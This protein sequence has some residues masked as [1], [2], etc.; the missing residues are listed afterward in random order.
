[1]AKLTVAE[2][3]PFIARAAGLCESDARVVRF[4]NRA[5]RRLLPKG[6]WVNTVQRYRICTNSDCITWPR[7]IETIEAFAV[8]GVPR[9]IRNGWFEFLPAGQGILSRESNNG[10]Q[11]ADRGTASTFDDITAGTWGYIRVYTDLPESSGKTIILQGYDENANWIRTLDS[12]TYIDGLKVTLPTTAGF[13]TTTQKFS[14][15]VRV[16]KSAT[17]GPV[18]LYEYNGTS[19]VRALAVYEPDETLP[20]Y[21]RSYVPGLRNIHASNEECPK[22][23]VE[24]M[25]KL[26]YYDVSKENDFLLIG[27]LPALEEMTRALVQFDNRTFAE[28]YTSERLAISLLQEELQS[29]QGEGQVLQ[30]RVDPDAGIGQVENVVS[31]GYGGY[32]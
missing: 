16:I 19:N 23:S 10:H 6:K 11:L 14:R 20:D 31:G 9:N 15:L 3:R 22:V 4:I 30:M 5:I 13:V 2:A 7:Q 26:K 12:G 27:C 25:A 32:W 1:M 24:V 29:F 17:N 18:R 8:D 28:A 21:R